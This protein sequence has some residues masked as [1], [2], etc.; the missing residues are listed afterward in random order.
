MALF[1][2]FRFKARRRKRALEGR[3]VEV[4]SEEDKGARIFSAKEV[5]RVSA[6]FSRSRVIGYG[7]SSTVYLGKFPDSSLAAVKTVDAGGS[8]RLQGIF[9]QELEILLRVKHDN[10]VKILGYSE[11]GTLVLEYVSNGT[12]RENLQGA[13]GSFLTWK[14]RAKIAFQI[15]GALDYLH[16]HAD[17]EI[18][19][20]DVKS[21]NIL[22]D[23]ALNCKLCDFGS[24]KFGLSSAAAL[25]PSSRRMIGSPGYADPH[26][27][28]T[29]I[30]SKKNDIYSFGVVMLELITGLDAVSPDG[31]GGGGRLIN[32]VGHMLKDV[33]KVAEMVDRRLLGECEL[34]EAMAMASLAALCLSEPPSLRPSASDI[35]ESMRNCVASLSSMDKN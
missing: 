7:G 17:T 16:R 22:L 25:P 35:M 1:G 2:C 4:S 20:G 11:E 30:A 14:N 8:N 29:G 6:N 34:G 5:E 10:I 28:K 18:V 27:L 3:R 21:S 12:L 33:S 13:K 26:Y 15:A 24:A 9:R 32:R 23:S 19:H 31:G